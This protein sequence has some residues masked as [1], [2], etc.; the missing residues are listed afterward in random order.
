MGTSLHQV[1]ENASAHLASSVDSIEGVCLFGSVARNDPGET[2]DID[3]L[4]LG[5]DPALTPGPLSQL[6]AGLYRDR[7]SI[8]YHTSDSLAEYLMRWSR[9]GVHLRTEGQ[10]LFDRHGHL[11][12]ALAADCPFS[13]RDELRLQ[14]L[15]LATFEHLERFGGRFLF[16]LAHLYLIGRT[17]VFALLAERGIFEF[18]QERAFERLPRVVPDAGPDVEKVA[19]LR[20]FSQLAQGRRPI[21]L[22]FG[23]EDCAPDVAAART[24]IRRLI[25]L[26]EHADVLAD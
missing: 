23:F 22:P 24:A 8:T 21:S 11:R 26:S 7:I 4:I 6:V 12:D 25:C 14:L 18:N 3:L 16:P 5:S 15:H 2:S 1:A 9:F 19:S 10:I 17:V 13:T 20:P